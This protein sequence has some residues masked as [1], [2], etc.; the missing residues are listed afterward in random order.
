MLDVLAIGMPGTTEMIIIGIIGIL[1][2]GNRLPKVAR[3]IGS[4]FIEFKKGLKGVESEIGDIKGELENT[5]QIT[6]REMAD[7]KQNSKV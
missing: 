6:N 3:G 7:T 5:R 4:S 1:I 2:F